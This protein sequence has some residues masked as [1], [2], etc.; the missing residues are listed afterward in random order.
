L[1]EK[2]YTIEEM[3]RFK[4]SKIWSL[5]QNYY[6]Q[7]GINA[8]SAGEVPHHMTSNAVVGKTYAGLIFAMLNDIALQDENSECVY[9]V[10]LGA[11]HGRLCYHTL[12]ELNNLIAI[13]KRKIPKYCYVLTDI[14]QANLD[15]FKAHPQFQK[16]IANKTLDVAY[17]DGGK[18]NTL[19]LQISNK[20]IEQGMLSSPVIIL[21]NYFFDAI[22]SDLY[23]IKNNKISQSLI[24]LTTIVS[25]G[26]IEDVALD[27][28]ELNYFYETIDLP[29]YDHEILDKI[30]AEYKDTLQDT[31]L[32]FPNE[33]LLCIDRLKA[34]SKK[35]G[36]LIT[37]DKGVQLASLLDHK[38]KPD[39]ITH[40][41]FSFTVNY[42]AFIRYA[43]LNGG[44]AMFSKYSNFHLELGVLLMTEDWTKFQSTI[45]AYKHLVDDY[46]PDDFYSLTKFS[47]DHI[48]SLGFQ[49]IISLLRIGSYDS[50]FFEN[51]LNQIKICIPKITYAERERLLQTLH[52]VWDMYFNLGES[53]LAFEIA[54][55][56]Y[57]LGYYQEA[58]T[59]FN[60]S[61][62]I[63]GHTQDSYF[64]KALCYFQLRKDVECKEVISASL[65]NFPAFTRISDITHMLAKEEA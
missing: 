2:I 5:N 44:R 32:I 20:T 28:I 39:W 33:S 30:L 34:L 14:A 53:D 54:G 10:E 16:Y 6:Q 31:H 57:D 37:M 60:H 64:N 17:F 1:E 19:Q 49:Q 55:L 63:Y 56:F 38:N 59:Y 36:L 21:A 35:G 46:G 7:K 51:L 41:S 8:W 45:E 40:G 65:I 26:R 27:D 23:K 12:K 48:T 62:A 61:I 42:H 9:L 15:F 47:Y 18:D 52:Q 11:G 29:I 25:Y 24:S 50:V 58:I 4:D 13:S 43:E 3:T 22:P